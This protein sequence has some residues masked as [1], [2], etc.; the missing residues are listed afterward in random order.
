M[1]KIFIILIAICGVMLTGCAQLVDMNDQQSDVLAEYM[2][3]S[4][5]R[6][7]RN[8]NES[9]V[10]PEETAETDEISE[11][12]SEN[13]KEDN[14]SAE[15]EVTAAA[16]N[17]QND[18][19]VSFAGMADYIGKGNFDITYSDYKFYDS[20][21]DENDYFTI[22]TNKGKKLLV[23]S[24]N[25]KNTTNKSRNFNL[26]KFKLKYRLNNNG[27]LYRP[28][29]TLLN[30]DIQY[31]NLDIAAGKTKKAVILFE[32][33]QDVDVPDTVLEITNKDKNTVLE[34]NP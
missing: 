4:V 10:Y 30:N 14:S 16:D 3:G 23:I 21:S 2:A 6:Y 12:I 29:M 34:L 32:V 27:I 9:L 25:I 31:I 7:T 1:R 5:L 33:P 13:T 15:P 11:T 17:T 24:F 28:M 26:S 22:E 18:N 20:Y 19:I 8:Y